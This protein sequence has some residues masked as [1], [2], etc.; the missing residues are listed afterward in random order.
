MSPQL[1][2][3]SV[4]LFVVAA[5][6][7]AESRLSRANERWL[8]GRGA[9]EPPDDVYRQMQWAYPAGFVLMAVEG[10]L[11]GPSPGAATLAGG[12]LFVA[13]KALKF[14]AIRSLG[15]RWTFRVLVLPDS[16]LVSRGPYAFVR[17]PN[18]LAVVGELLGVALLVGARVTGPGATALFGWLLW[19]RIKVEEHALRHPPCT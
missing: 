13:A 14:W 10:A 5:V 12:V 7:L 11:A 17:H 2:V 16:P 18:Y 8:R 6:M 4:A 9:I 1:L 15:R 3:A 19:N